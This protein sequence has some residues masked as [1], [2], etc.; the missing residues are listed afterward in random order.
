MSENSSSCNP[1]INKIEYCA[2][3]NDILLKRIEYC[4]GCNDIL[5]KRI[6][7]YNCLANLCSKCIFLI[8]DNEYCFK[9]INSS[10]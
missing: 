9:C 6:E 3:C 4:I 1:E 8:D 2:G 5:L 7:C 10:F